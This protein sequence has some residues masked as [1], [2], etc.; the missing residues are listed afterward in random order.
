V[1]SVSA[2][3][4]E[5]TQD[6]TLGRVVRRCPTTPYGFICETELSGRCCHVSG[7]CVADLS[8]V[9]QAGASPERRQAVEVSRAEVGH[10]GLALGIHELVGSGD[11]VESHEVP[12]F[13]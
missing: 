10:A 3:H 2:W 12:Q 5:V 6:V 7:V 8:Q 11:V 9:G 4:G 13:V 1:D